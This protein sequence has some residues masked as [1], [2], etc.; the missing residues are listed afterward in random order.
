MPAGIAQA[1]ATRHTF[2]LFN[3]PMPALGF[4]KVEVFVHFQKIYDIQ[5]IFAGFN[6]IGKVIRALIKINIELAGRCI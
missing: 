6:H 5:I 2:F 1:R 4:D 3:R